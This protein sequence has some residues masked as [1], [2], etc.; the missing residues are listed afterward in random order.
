MKKLYPVITALTASLC[1]QAAILTT[2]GSTDM[3]ETKIW[4]KFD[5]APKNPA[6]KIFEKKSPEKKSDGKF[7]RIGGDYNPEIYAAVFE[8]LAPNTEYSFEI[9]DGDG[10]SAGSLKTSPD[11]KDRTP[12]PDFSFV[13][14]GENHINDKRFDEPFK[15]PGGEYA[16]FDAA[17][18]TAPAFAI[19]AGSTNAY[20]HADI[21]SRSGMLSRQLELRALPEARGMLNAQ[22]N[23]GTLGTNTLPDASSRGAKNHIAV[24]DVIWCNPQAAENSSRAY[25]FS[26]ADAD[27]F[28]LDDFSNRSNLDYKQTRPRMLGKSQLD[29]LFTALQNSKATFKFVVMNTPATNPV[30]SAENFTFAKDERKSL[31]A[32][33][34]DK[35]IGGVVFISGKKGY[36][37]ITR[38]IRAGS[39]P[40][41]EITAGPATARPSKEIAE[42]NYFRVPSSATLA[43]SFAQI[44]VEGAEGART[45]TMTFVNS[46]GD[47]LF[48]TTIKQADLQKFE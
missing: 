16:I 1:A 26:Y 44:K 12:P 8:N 30:E 22:P 34:S 6:A 14:L 2:V 21:G 48:S 24:F 5:S 42:M 7:V 38:H 15:E 19:W 18:K 20:R 45:L 35:K 41:Y 31:L 28:V 36:G 32:F 10:V 46:K 40:I 39:Y 9:T 25:T 43:R 37:E 29:W 13:V 23:Y 11:Y 4:V 47:A 3:R 27:F 33:L 17:R